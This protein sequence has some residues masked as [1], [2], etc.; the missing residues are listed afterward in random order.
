MT[1]APIRYHDGIETLSPDENETIDRIIAAMT[2][3]SEITAKR[4]GHAVRASHAKISGVAV[5][6]LEILPNL[7]P[8]LAQGLFANAVTH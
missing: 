1:A 3:E 4:Y 5:G 6:T 8:E 2:H 7:Q